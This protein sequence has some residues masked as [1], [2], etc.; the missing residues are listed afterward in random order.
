MAG[1]SPVGATELLYDSAMQ[2][3]DIEHRS[4]P[5]FEPGE[6]GELVQTG[7]VW[8]DRMY[9]DPELLLT[10]AIGLSRQAN[11]HHYTQ[12]KSEVPA[13]GVDAFHLVRLIKAAEAV[14]AARQ[15]A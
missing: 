15:P 2:I 12:G 5:V 13:L 9:E 1:G 7:D 3:R 10:H 6:N 8:P 11:V 4:V 14:L